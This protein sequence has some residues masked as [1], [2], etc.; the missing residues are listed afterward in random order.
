MYALLFRCAWER[1]RRPQLTRDKQKRIASTGTKD[2]ESMLAQRWRSR[3]TLRLSMF[4]LAAQGPLSP[5]RCDA[6]STSLTTRSQ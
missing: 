3:H 5:K 4:R 6:A 2:R 1:T